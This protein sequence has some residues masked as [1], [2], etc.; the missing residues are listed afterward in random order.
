MIGCKE[1]PKPFMKEFNNIDPVPTVSHETMLA[2]LR[3]RQNL[4]IAV[5][6]GCG[7][8]VLGAVLWAVITV[9]TGY[10]IGWMAVGIGFLVG[11]GVRLGKG[12]DR[13]YNVI[14]AVLALV[15]CV[16]GNIFAVMGIASSTLG[17]GFWDVRMDLAFEVMKESFSL[18]DLL[19]YGIAI[20]EGW[21]FSTKDPEIA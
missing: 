19:F 17:V 21:R 20:Y 3:M 18:M 6:A 14:G 2:E 13:I 11:F 15:G 4:P 7:A 1:L 10:Q 8:A 5:L 9:V 16:F 12:I